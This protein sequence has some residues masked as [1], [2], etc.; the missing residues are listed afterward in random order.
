TPSRLKDDKNPQ[1]FAKTRKI[2][3]KFHSRLTI[4]DGLV[5]DCL[6]VMTLMYVRI[7]QSAII[8]PFAHRKD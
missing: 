2:H 7:R 3:A 6:W 4:Y 8:R 5:A 1:F